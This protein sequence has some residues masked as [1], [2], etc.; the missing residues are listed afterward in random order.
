MAMAM[1]SY[2]SERKRGT[3]IAIAAVLIA[4]SVAFVVAVQRKGGTLN[5]AVLVP[6][7]VGVALLFRRSGGWLEYRA[8]EDELV[9]TRRTTMQTKVSRL[10]TKELKALSVVGAKNV[11]QLRLELTGDKHFVLLESPNERALEADREVVSAFLTEQKL[12]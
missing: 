7:G 11:K 3:T 6:A 1:V 9:V 2:G 8:G 4:I 12:L 10:A 5:G